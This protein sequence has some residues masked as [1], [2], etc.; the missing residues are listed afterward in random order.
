MN[1]GG[2]VLEGGGS[3]MKSQTLFVTL[4]IGTKQ[5]P[6]SGT[7]F[8]TEKCRAASTSEGEEYSH[9]RLM[10]SYLVRQPPT[11]PIPHARDDHGQ[12]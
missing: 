2:K 3:E 10:L 12:L 5:V 6:P 8:G 9:G 4:L 11:D 7:S 1:V